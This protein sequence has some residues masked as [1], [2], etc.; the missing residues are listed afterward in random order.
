MRFIDWRH[1]II[2][3]GM[4]NGSKSVMF[5]LFFYLLL[6]ILLFILSKISI[7]KLV[8]SRHF[9]KDQIAYFIKKI[10]TLSLI[11]CFFCFFSPTN[12]TKFILSSLTIF[13]AFHFIEAVIVQNK[14]NMK[15]SNG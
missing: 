8:D 2:V 5:F 6:I 1:S 15:D 3:S 12:S 7:Q 14:I 13:V 9:I 4:E 11:T 10:I